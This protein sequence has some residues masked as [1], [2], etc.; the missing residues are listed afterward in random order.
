MVESMIIEQ[1]LLISSVRK[2]L[3]KFSTNQKLLIIK[4][5]KDI[6]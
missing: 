6:E 3:V 2:T 1:S 4:M 5:I